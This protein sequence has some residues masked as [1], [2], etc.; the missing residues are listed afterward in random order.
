MVGADQSL[1][2]V[3]RWDHRVTDAAPMAQALTRLEQVLNTEIAAEIRA[4]RQQNEAAFQE[5]AKKIDASK[6]A[7]AVLLAMEREHPKPPELLKTSQN[8]LD[9]IRQFIVPKNIITIPP[10]DPA[11]VKETPP[12]MR[13][14]TSASMDTPGPFETAK[15]D[16][17]YNMTLPDPR[18]TAAEQEDYM[19]SWYYAQMSNVAV[20]EVYPGH[21]IQFLYA[22]TSARSTA[23]AP[24]AKAGRIT[25]SR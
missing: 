25:A 20:H 16:A 13:S 9:E 21:Y 23:P 22:K 4:N 14:T 15:L 5:T 6:P 12:F 19:R 18:R 24:T 2:V 7:D 1:D 3:L 11:T 8:S 17:F 10:S